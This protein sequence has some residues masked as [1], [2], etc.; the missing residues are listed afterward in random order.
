MTALPEGPVV[1]AE[2]ASAMA[3]GARRVL[4][5]DVGVAVTGVAGPDPQDGHGPGVVFVGFDLGS[6]GGDAGPE[7]FQ[8]QLPGDRQ[9]VRQF[10]VITALSA[11]RARLLASS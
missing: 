6:A 3:A 7:A 11:L 2:A 8:V 1:S 4:G 9:Q 5:A 10:S